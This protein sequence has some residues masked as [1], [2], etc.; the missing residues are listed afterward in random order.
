MVSYFKIVRSRNAKGLCLNN[1]TNQ[2]LEF[3]FSSSCHFAFSVLSLPLESVHQRYEGQS[4][5]K[6]D[7]AD[8]DQHNFSTSR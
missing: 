2:N 4:D 7:A 3:F 6:A 8:S 5:P 1:L